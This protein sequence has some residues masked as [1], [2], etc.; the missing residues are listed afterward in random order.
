MQ[1]LTYTY[2]VGGWVGGSKFG[3]KHAYVMY[4]WSLKCLVQ[5]NAKFK[6]HTILVQEIFQHVRPLVF[7]PQNRY[8]AFLAAGRSRRQL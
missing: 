1:N 7:Y 8:D 2:K 3:L 4:E 6:V 5:G